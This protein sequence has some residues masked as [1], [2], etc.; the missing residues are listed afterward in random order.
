MP[1]SPVAAAVTAALLI[2]TD[3]AALYEVA[4]RLRPH[5]SAR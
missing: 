5:G 1:P 3:I 2:I 4:V